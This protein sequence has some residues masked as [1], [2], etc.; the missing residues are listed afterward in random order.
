MVACFSGSQQ[1]AFEDESSWAEDV[2]T[3]SYAVPISSP[4]EYSGITQQMLD[5]ARMTSRRLAYSKGVLGPWDISFTLVSNLTGHGSTCAGAISATSLVR[6]LGGVF[7]G[8]DATLASGTTATGG[9]ATIP[10]LTAASGF[11]AGGMVRFGALGDGD[12]EGQFYPFS[13][14]SSNNLNLLLA[15]A[16]APVNGAVVYSPELVYPA[17]SSCAM[18][19]R[20][21][22]L[23][24]NDMQFIVHGCFPTA[25]S[26]QG[27]GPNEHPQV[28]VTWRGSWAEPIAGSFPTTP[29]ADEFNWQPASAGGSFI[30]QDVGTTT[31]AS[32]GLRAFSI[33][34]TL[35]MSPVMGGSGVNQYQVITGATRTKDVIMWN[36][37]VDA[38]GADATP[39]FW[40]SWGNNTPQQAS[41][42]L[43]SADGTSLNFDARNMCWM[44]PRPSQS[45]L[46]E[47]NVINLQWRCDITSTTT[48]D[49]TLAPMR[50]AFG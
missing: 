6:Y 9:T 8:R 43:S 49:L 42:T 46:N 48:S 20:R 29:N 13:T 38:Q 21:F 18:T 3:M 4:V 24:S 26:L 35:G 28:S 27:L 7:G 2:D 47:R 44:G 16:G 22:R 30:L 36:A 5:A 12:G 19:G 34:Y 14:H 17:D 23:L 10:T 25:V 31:R 41:Y 39:Q 15:L 33:G 11:P 37:T 50:I 45:A 40:D 1:V 32:Y